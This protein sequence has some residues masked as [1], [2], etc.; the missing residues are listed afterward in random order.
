[1]PADI[2]PL[3]EAEEAELRKVV[4]EMTPGPYNIVPRL[5]ATIAELRDKGRRLVEYATHKPDCHFWYCRTCDWAV[6]TNRKRHSKTGYGD[7]QIDRGACNCGLS[8]LP[9]AKEVC[10]D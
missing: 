4:E 3:S 8:E 6:K 9:A 7:H 5:L 10:G 2:Q 1:M